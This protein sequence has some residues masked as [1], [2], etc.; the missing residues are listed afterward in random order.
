MA[1]PFADFP[2]IGDPSNVFLSES[3]ITEKHIEEHILLL[4]R[5]VRQLTYELIEF[6]PL[7]PLYQLMCFVQ[8]TVLT[9]LDFPQNVI[10]PLTELFTSLLLWPLAYQVHCILPEVPDAVSVI[11][12]V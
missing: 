2:R 11:E 10:S 1:I 6:P 4:L 5:L 12:N 7:D 9:Q 8:S 3:L